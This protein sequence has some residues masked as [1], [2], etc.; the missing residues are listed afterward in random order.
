M[1]IKASLLSLTLLAA[2]AAPVLAEDTSA[3][4]AATQTNASVSQDKP[5]AKAE[6]SSKKAAGK[7]KVR[8]H[9]K[10]AK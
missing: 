7:H 1:K 4:P 10:E 8:T 2:V 3:V 9:K 6:K 5:A